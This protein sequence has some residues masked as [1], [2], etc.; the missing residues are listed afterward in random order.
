MVNGAFCLG[1]LSLSL[2]KDFSRKQVE[3]LKI[4]TSV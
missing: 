3:L 2:N 4:I 1:D